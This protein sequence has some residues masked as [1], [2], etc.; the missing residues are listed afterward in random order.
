MSMI[1]FI[2]ITITI[3][4]LIYCTVLYFRDLK[5]GKDSFVT[6]T[7]RWIKNIIDVLFGAG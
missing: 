5:I 4:F 6:K 2:A 3:I 1:T 7:V